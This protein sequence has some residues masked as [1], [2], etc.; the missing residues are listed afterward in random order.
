MDT[1]RNVKRHAIAMDDSKLIDDKHR[2]RLAGHA[3]SA[4]SKALGREKEAYL[5]LVVGEK[6]YSLS[7]G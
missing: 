1:E 5:K 6:L 4:K 3:P 2:M 7:H